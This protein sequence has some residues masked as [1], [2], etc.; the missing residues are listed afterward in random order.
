VA[1]GNSFVEDEK[2]PGERSF[3]AWRV[4]GGAALEGFL[5]GRDETGASSQGQKSIL[6]ADNAD[7]A[8]GSAALGWRGKG[9][10]GR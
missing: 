9:T 3:W 8:D 2:I 1:K 10:I 5:A 4:G 7:N 6:T